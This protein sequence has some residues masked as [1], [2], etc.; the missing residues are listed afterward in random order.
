[1]S[2][3]IILILTNSHY[4]IVWS[5]KKILHAIRKIIF[6]TAIENTYFFNLLLLEYCRVVFLY[7]NNLE[8]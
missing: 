2:I 4:I 5:I 1:M 6:P 8:S 3:E 7:Q